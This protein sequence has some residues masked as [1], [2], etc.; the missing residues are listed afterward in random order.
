MEQQNR[1]IKK[2]WPKNNEKVCLLSAAFSS[3]VDQTPAGIVLTL[4]ADLRPGLASGKRKNRSGR[5]RK[6]WNSFQDRLEVTRR[7]LKNLSMCDIV[8]IQNQFFFFFYLVMSAK[9]FTILLN[10]VRRSQ[11]GYQLLRKMVPPVSLIL[12]SFLSPFV[13]WLR[14][15]VDD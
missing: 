11:A 9:G 8:V 3:V 1:K 4:L 10:R 13:S 6:T 12:P 7:E 15:L 2:A 5:R 14:F